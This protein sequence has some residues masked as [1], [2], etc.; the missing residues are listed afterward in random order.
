T[1]C[2]GEGPGRAMASLAQGENSGPESPR[3]TARECGIVRRLGGRAVSPWTGG[4]GGSAGVWE[5]ETGGALGATACGALG[6]GDRGG[7]CHAGAR[8][9][10]DGAGHALGAAG[11]AGDRPVAAP[12]AVA[13]AGYP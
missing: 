8:A 10:L 4:A 11:G 12:V 13:A 2:G 3:I 6:R 5:L 1:G 7:G 9:R